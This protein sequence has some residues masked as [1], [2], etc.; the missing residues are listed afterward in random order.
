[1]QGLRNRFPRNIVSIF[2]IITLMILIENKE[3]DLTIVKRGTKNNE[4]SIINKFFLCYLK[5]FFKKEGLT[6]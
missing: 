6:L 1:M 5:E 2:R 3:L 4:N